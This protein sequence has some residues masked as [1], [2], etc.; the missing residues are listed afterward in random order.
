MLLEVKARK[1]GMEHIALT[2]DILWQIWKAR[3]E[4]EF[5]DKERHPMEVIRKAIKDWKEYH[6]SQQTVHHMSISKT[7]IA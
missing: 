3:N 4:S 6:Q 7:K 1:D 2:E 5:E